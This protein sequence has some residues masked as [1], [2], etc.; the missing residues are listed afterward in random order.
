MKQHRHRFCSLLIAFFLGIFLSAVV[1]VSAG[2][3][4]QSGACV[5]FADTLE[6]RSGSKLTHW[7]C[8]QE[9]FN[10]SRPEVSVSRSIHARIRQNIFTSVAVSSRLIF[11][12]AFLEVIF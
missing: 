10:Q 1:P 8:F 3:N 9:R 2:T 11:P 7:K 12:G 5:E 4:F 6:P